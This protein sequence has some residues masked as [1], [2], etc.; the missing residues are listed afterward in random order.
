LLINVTDL[1]QRQ[2]PY[3]PVPGDGDLFN[4]LLELTDAIVDQVPA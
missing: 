4:G 3:R 1:A 2:R